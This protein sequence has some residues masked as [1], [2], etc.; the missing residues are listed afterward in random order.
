M[1][2][3]FTNHRRF[4][5]LDDWHREAVALRAESVIHYIDRTNDDFPP[6]WAVL[7][8]DEVIAVERQPALFTNEPLSVLGTR[9]YLAALE[10]SGTNLR[11]L[12]QMDAPDH[13][14][15]AVSPPTG[16]SRR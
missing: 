2:D 1:T 15:T 16:S 10:A 11:P 7:G 9:S 4:A 8:L 6:F 5:D 14:S 12:T 3:L 13:P